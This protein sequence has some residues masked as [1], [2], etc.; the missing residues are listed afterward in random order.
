MGLSG[1][2]KRAK[3]VEALI[4]KHQ[5]NQVEN[6]LVKWLKDVVFPAQEKV[7]KQRGQGGTRKPGRGEERGK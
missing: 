3:G 5:Q 6:A 4:A 1:D 2:K 7:N